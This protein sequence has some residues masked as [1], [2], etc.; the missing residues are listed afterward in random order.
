MSITRDCVKVIKVLHSCRTSEQ[1]E[2]ATNMAINFGRKYESNEAKF[3]EYADSI[4]ELL[5]TKG[6]E[7]WEIESEP[8]P[9]G[10]LKE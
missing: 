5:E 3:S 9:I 8:R 7:L 6:E 2:T 10:F 1:F 4:N